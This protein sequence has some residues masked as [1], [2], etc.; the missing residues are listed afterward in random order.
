MAIILC[1]FTEI[2]TLWATYI[3]VVEV[4]P[5]LSTT[6]IQS[7]EYGFWQLFT[8]TFSEVTQKKCIE[9]RYLV[10]NS[11]NLNCAR[12]CDHVMANLS[13]IQ[14]SYHY[15]TYTGIRQETLMPVML[16]KLITVQMF[17]TIAAT[18]THK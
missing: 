4:R 9:D 7:K 11:E 14:L 8:V 5:T 10:L 15:C 17:L 13:K 16:H 18:H 2:R 6:E 1:Y 12:L 3:T